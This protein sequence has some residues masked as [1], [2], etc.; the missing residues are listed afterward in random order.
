MKDVYRQGF[1][2]YIYCILL[3]WVRDFNPS[4]ARDFYSSLRCSGN[5]NG[6]SI[7]AIKLSG[8]PAIQLV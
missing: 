5:A 3:R 6:G 8:L 4:E 1:C 7:S 2:R